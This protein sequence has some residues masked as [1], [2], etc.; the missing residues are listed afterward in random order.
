MDS[1]RGGAPSADSRN[2]ARDDLSALLRLWQPDLEGYSRLIATITIL[3]NHFCLRRR[4]D[5]SCSLHRSGCA[6]ADGCRRLPPLYAQPQRPPSSFRGLTQIKV[7]VPILSHD[8]GIA[9]P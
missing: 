6:A 7:N 3:F 5:R 8:R 1:N 2:T 9:F 4:G